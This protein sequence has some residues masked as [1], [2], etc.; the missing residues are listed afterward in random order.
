MDVGYSA[1]FRGFRLIWI[2]ML[3][4]SGGLCVLIC[5]TMLICGAAIAAKA[6]Q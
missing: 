5:L 6:A 4:V 3:A 2:L 1:Q